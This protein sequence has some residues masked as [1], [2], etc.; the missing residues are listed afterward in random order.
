MLYK[1]KKIGGFTLIELLIYISILSVITFIVADSFIMLNKGRASVEAKSE[2]NSNLRFAAEKMERDIASA[3]DLVELINTSYSTSHITFLSGGDTIS[4]L[5]F[6]N[7]IIRRVNGSSFEYITS[8]K[9]NITN[10]SFVR[11]E[12]I[13]NF[14]SKRIISVEINI[15]G[16]YNST[17]PDWQYS[18][19]QTVS[20]SLNKVFDPTQIVECDGSSG[21]FLC[22][23]PCSY[24]GDI[25]STVLLDTQC[26]FADNLRTT[27]YPNDTAITKGAAGDGGGFG[28][29]ATA[30]YSCPPNDSGDGSASGEDCA[31]AGSPLK[32]G[33]LYQ[34]KAAANGAS[35]VTGDTG[36]RGICPNN[37]HIPADNLSA[38]SDF[39]KLIAT[40][41]AISGCNGNEA[42]CLRTGGASN[43]NLPWAGYRT[44]DGWYFKRTDGARL[45]TATDDQP[46]WPRFD[47]FEA[48]APSRANN[49]SNDMAVSVR[50]VHD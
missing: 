34:R 9:V 46:G 45:W 47:K 22:G 19:S 48:S 6:S 7:R 20:T 4:Y 35:S 15:S 10:L 13:N 29:S 11:V 43:F 24:K 32:L 3:S 39:G 28:S 18:Q 25:Y 36:P 2:L 26:W 12:N 23:N 17:S 27:V 41:S 14:F 1:F 5:V 37:W 16:S 31:A 44:A 8:D 38:T 49:N 50:C 33:M 42:T 30:Y 40:V 21:T